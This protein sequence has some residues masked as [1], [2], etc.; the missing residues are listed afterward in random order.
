MHAELLF[1]KIQSTHLEDVLKEDIS[2]S[3]LW[4]ASLLRSEDGCSSIIR[5]HFDFLEAG[6][7]I[8]STST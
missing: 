3:P 8:I 7:Q 2:S 6:A 4:S 1:L 5:T